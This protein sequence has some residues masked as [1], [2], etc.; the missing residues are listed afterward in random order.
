M[1]NFITDICLNIITKKEWEILPKYGKNEEIHRTFLTK[2]TRFN[3]YKDKTFYFSR[4]F[5]KSGNSWRW[6]VLH[7]SWRH[8]SH[9]REKPICIPLEHSIINS[10][11]IRLYCRKNMG[12]LDILVHHLSPCALVYQSIHFLFCE[13]HAIMPDLDIGLLWS[14]NE[15]HYVKC[16]YIVVAQ[17]TLL[18]PIPQVISWKKLYL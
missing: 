12:H 4:R 5:L 2:P 6:K 1:S 8:F 15:V 3:V 16:L 18:F 17:Q 11:R 13:V 14:L 7:H 10:S 9:E